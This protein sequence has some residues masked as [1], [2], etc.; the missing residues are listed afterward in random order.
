MIYT[1]SKDGQALTNGRSFDLMLVLVGIVSEKT[2]EE[3]FDEYYGTVDTP[4][5]EITMSLLMKKYLSPQEFEE[6]QI[7]I[8]RDL[9]EIWKGDWEI[10]GSFVESIDYDGFH[11]DRFLEEEDNEEREQMRTELE[12]AILKITTEMEGEW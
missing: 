10:T 7:E 9:I 2:V 6:F 11:I 4:V 12:T 3:V 8:A 1:I 5:G